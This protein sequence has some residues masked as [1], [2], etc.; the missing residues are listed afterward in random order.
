MI[1]K[2]LITGGAGYVGSALSDELIRKNYN[3]TV[4]DLFIYGKNVFK[5]SSK[6]QLINGDIRDQNLLRKI[7][8]GHDAVIHLACISNDP[9]FELN[10]LLGKSINLDAFDPLV[11]IS[12]DSGVKRFIYASSSSVYGIKDELNVHEE[13]DL[14]PLTDYSKFKANCEE[15]CL[16][17][18]SKNFDVL[19]IRPATVCGYSMRQR[20][21]LVVNIL[22]NL[23]INK[24]KITVFGGEQLRPNI[25]IKDMIRAYVTT[26]EKESALINGK[27]FN[28]GYDNQ[29]VIELANIVKKYIN[30]DI[31]IIKT[32]TNDNRSYHIS[33][34]KIKKELGFKNMYNTADAVKDIKNAFKLNL[35]NDSLNN[36]IYFNV[37]MMKKIHLQ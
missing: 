8:P 37:K 36:E 6:I 4:L 16:K 11:K 21:D 29:K 15:I 19:V 10:P 33:S 5:N 7:I 22:T 34:D 2:V 31:E 20:F 3:V 25:H 13:M 27:I 1:K 17:H 32:G 14:K 30:N 9:S 26:L 28:V 18:N 35:F 23:G 24:K 12:K